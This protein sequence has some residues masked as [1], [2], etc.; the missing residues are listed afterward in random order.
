MFKILREKQASGE[1]GVREE[2]LYWDAE[3]SAGSGDTSH[4]KS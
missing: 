3:Y 1:P 2:E 4:G